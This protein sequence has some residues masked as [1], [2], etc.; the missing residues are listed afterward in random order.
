[1]YFEGLFI[2]WRP[3]YPMKSVKF[4]KVYIFEELLIFECLILEIY[5]KYILT[6]AIY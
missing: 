6:K 2:L 3:P 5:S 4:M 1:M